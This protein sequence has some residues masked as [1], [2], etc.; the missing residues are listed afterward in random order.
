MGGGCAKREARACSPDMVEAGR[1]TPP[2]EM[3]A[4]HAV[5]GFV[6]SCGC[7][8]PPFPDS[9]NPITSADMLSTASVDMLENAPERTLSEMRRVCRPGSTARVPRSDAL[10]ARSSRSSCRPCT[11]SLSWHEML[12][13]S[14]ME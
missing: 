14:G 12:T 7:S 9:D 10:P 1:W 5:E 6:T 13:K 11:E 2:A 8:F 4:H 3:L